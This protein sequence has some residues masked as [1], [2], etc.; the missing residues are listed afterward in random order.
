MRRTAAAEAGTTIALR[1]FPSPGFG[2]D[3]LYWV[4]VAFVASAKSHRLGA[5]PPWRG[6]KTGRNGAV[7]MLAQKL[8]TEQIWKAID[9]YLAH[10]YSGPL[11]SPVRAKLDTLRSLPP[12]EFYSSPILERDAPA[13]ASP[14]KLSLRLGNKFYPHM[15]LTIEQ[16]PDQQRF[17]FRAD[18]HD[19]HCCPA[20]ESREY[21]PFCQLM[22]GNQQI[23]QAIEAE[24]AKEGLP[25]FKTYL[26][27]DLA[28][29]AKAAQ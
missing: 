25:T 5:G 7:V 26:R 3:R 18:T 4:I 12:E 2:P 10:A 19:R 13:A 9:V 22:E 17:L 1:L 24:W 15:K 11:P 21:G 28:R 6:V 16:S 23:A 20:P 8:P 14:G 27:D 29:R